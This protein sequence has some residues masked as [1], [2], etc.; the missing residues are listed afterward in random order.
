MRSVAARAPDA[1]DEELRSRLAV[2]APSS[3]EPDS[4]PEARKEEK[5]EASEEEAAA[6]LG[7]LFG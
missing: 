2:S 5:K 7:A 3:R 1:L 6:G 4:K